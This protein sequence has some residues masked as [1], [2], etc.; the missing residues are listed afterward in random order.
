MEEKMILL[1]VLCVVIV[2]GLVFLHLRNRK[3][4]RD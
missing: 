1:I 2:G 3:K 4:K